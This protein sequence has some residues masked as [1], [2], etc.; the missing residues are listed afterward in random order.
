[1]DHGQ[2]SKVIG[3]KKEASQQLRITE[4]DLFYTKKERDIDQLQKV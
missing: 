4:T 1:V 3:E 2:G